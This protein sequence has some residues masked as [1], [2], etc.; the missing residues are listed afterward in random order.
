VDEWG[1]GV[2]WRRRQGNLTVDKARG[3]NPRWS[4][5]LRTRGVR[6]QKSRALENMLNPL[7]PCRTFKRDVWGAVWKIQCRCDAT[8]R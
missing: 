4:P 6:K 1:V 3:G 8:A 5:D 7:N 2:G